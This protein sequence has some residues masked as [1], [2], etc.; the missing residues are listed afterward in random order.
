MTPAEWEAKLLIWGR[1]P[2][3][4]EQ[5]KMER[6]EGEIRAAIA[7]S[8]A[9]SSH[10]VKV[11][12]QGSYRN[13]THIPRESDVDICVVCKD[14]VD[15]DW[16]FVDPRAPSD[17]A[18]ARALMTRYRLTPASYTYPQFKIDVG[19]ALVAR[20]GPPP[21]VTSGDKA[22]NI[23]ETRYNV[24]A[25]VVA[26]LEHRRY[27]AD[28]TYDE[29]TQFLSTKG[30]K[31]INWPDQQHANGVTKNQATRERFKAMV[32]VLKNLC[33]EM[34]DQ[35]KAAAK[36]MSSFLIECLVY[37][38]PDSKFGHA[39][40]YDDLREVL[41]FLF[42]NTQT[43]EECENWLEESR[44]KWLFRGDKGWTRAQVNAFVLAA[45]HHIGYTN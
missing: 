45:W 35:G 39:T 44:L 4:P 41:R 25:D 31:I 32:R 34:D 20:F 28:G 40:Y 7:A 12:A 38:V 9:L 11:F 29:G 24:D 33:H 18:V 19:A 21:A 1:A 37:N 13:L 26:A 22:F 17:P 6:T 3:K 42:L 30:K 36:P 23:R 10:Q 15:L 16:Q 8:T 2:G 43:D 5:D 14:V 27:R